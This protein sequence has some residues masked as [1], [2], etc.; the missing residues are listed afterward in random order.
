[1]ATASVVD[2]RLL[3]QD[4]YE[5]WVV[6]TEER[7]IEEQDPTLG[8]KDLPWFQGRMSRSVA[9]DRL[10]KSARFDGTFLVRESD[11]LSVH[12]EPVY[13]ISVMLNGD[14]HHVE[15]I[16]HSNSKYTVANINN[17]KEFKSLN[18]LI[19]YYRNK[20]LDLEGG[21]RTKLKYFIG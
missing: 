1:M 3:S 6:I 16:K 18:K 2:G 20:P 11:A 19:K 8:N 10:S 13:M 7:S 5:D 4:Y 21:G 17:A 14:T 15:V 9:E 12:R